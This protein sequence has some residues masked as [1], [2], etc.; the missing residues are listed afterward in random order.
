M[1]NECFSKYGIYFLP[2][3]HSLLQSPAIL[4]KNRRLPSAEKKY[5]VHPCVDSSLLM[6]AWAISSSTQDDGAE[7]GFCKPVTTSLTTQSL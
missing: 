3:P 2:C 6:A 4:G 5:R 1:D 7:E